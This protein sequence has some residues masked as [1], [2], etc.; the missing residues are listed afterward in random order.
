MQASLREMAKITTGLW[1]HM[2]NNFLFVNLSENSDFFP[3]KVV[4]S[5]SRAVLPHPPAPRII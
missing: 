1:L 3:K 2:E 4:V 5:F